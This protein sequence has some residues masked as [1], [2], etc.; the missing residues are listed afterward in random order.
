MIKITII[1]V[2]YNSEKTIEATIKSVTNQKKEGLDLEY[3]IVDGNS[4]D[5]TI[6]IIDKYKRKISKVVSENDSGIY[7]AM[8]KGIMLSTGDIIGFLNSDD[9]YASN[10]I[11]MMVV[12]SFRKNKVSAVYGDLVYTDRDDLSKIKRYWKSSHFKRINLNKGWMPPHPS[13]FLRKECYELHGIF[14]QEFRS[15]AD[16]ELILRIFKQEGIS[17]RY[18]NK[19]F[20]KMREGGTSNASVK[21]R[22]KSIKEDYNALRKN[23]FQNRSLIIFL[24]II[25]KLPQFFFIKKYNI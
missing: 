13:L 14:D 17:C 24:K 15:A 21:S 8:N 11:L 7:D 9:V 25:S 16:Y 12:E 10:N 23:K 5:N 6:R 20:V 3:I 1:T 22:I 4:S 19:V 18:I 2:A